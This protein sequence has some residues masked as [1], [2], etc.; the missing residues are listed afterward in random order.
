MPKTVQTKLV[1]VGNS[2]GVRIP[3]TL[4]QLAGLTDEVELEAHEHQIVIRSLRRPRQGWSEAFMAMA[5]AG[6]DHLLE[7]D[8]LGP[9]DDW[10]WE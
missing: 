4:L 10:Q 7:A 9:M 2:R 3:A 8:E 6:D 1:R 5:Q